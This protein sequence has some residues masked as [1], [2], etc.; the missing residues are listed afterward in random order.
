MQR[1]A[2]FICLGLVSIF[3]AVCFPTPCGAADRFLTYPHPAASDGSLW[4][5]QTWTYTN[6]TAHKGFDFIRGTP[7]RSITWV[8]FS[9]LCAAPGIVD[10]VNTNPAASTWGNYVI[11]KH[12]KTDFSPQLSTDYYTVYAHLKDNSIRV[13][14]GKVVARG[15]L[16]GTSG[17]SGAANGLLHLHFEVHKTTKMNKVDPFSIH[18]TR[19]YYPR[20]PNYRKEATRTTAEDRGTLWTTTP[21]KTP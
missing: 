1:F 17:K 9:V 8:E 14:Q 3:L 13:L 15:T 10:T 7:D 18:S 19:P 2:S 12:R 16:L 6:N 21:P 4:I 11:V 20:W 5:Q